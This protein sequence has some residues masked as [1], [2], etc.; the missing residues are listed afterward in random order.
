[1]VSKN[2]LILA[3]FII[4]LIAVAGCASQKTN[5]NNKISGKATDGA[6][7]TI[8]KSS[9]CGC[10]GVYSQYMEKRGFNVQVVDTE[11]LDSIKGK[12]KVPVSMQ[13]CHT[14]VIENYFVEGHVPAEAIEKLLAEKPDI[15]GIAMPGMPSGSPGMPG[16]KRGPFMVYAVNKDGSTAEFMRI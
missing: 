5:G 16:S 1:M 12:Y 13:S 15:A 9:G 2:K 6:A 7:A 14:T 10:C 8:F 11:D 4:G 3:L